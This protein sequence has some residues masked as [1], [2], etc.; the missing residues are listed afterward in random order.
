MVTNW[1]SCIRWSNFTPCIGKTIQNWKNIYNKSRRLGFNCKEWSSTKWLL[2]A[3][4]LYA[5]IFLSVKWKSETWL[6]AKNRLRNILHVDFR[7]KYSTFWLSDVWPKVEFDTK[8]HIFN[9]HMLRY[10]ENCFAIYLVQIRIFVSKWLFDLQDEIFGSQILL[11]RPIKP[12]NQAH[13]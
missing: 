7:A 10:P 11:L 6:T 2:G 9:I 1:I 8:F 4:F 5:S 12:L 13:V 3:N